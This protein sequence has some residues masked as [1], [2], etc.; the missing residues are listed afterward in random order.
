MKGIGFK[1]SNDTAVL[2]L[3]KDLGF[4]SDDGTPT[5]RYHDY[6]DKSRSKAVMAEALREA[7]EGVFHISEKPGA[8]DRSAIIG[9]FKAEHNVSDRVAQQSTTTFY[10]LLKLADLDA[11]RGSPPR[12]KKTVSKGEEAKEDIADHERETPPSQFGSVGLRY[13][14]EIHLP[15]SKDIEVYNAI[16]KSLK[17]HLIDD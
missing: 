12:K 3:L 17:E 11:Q 16:F 5:R 9:K 15:A 7:Y 10:A 2:P 1:S 8:S 14:V 4:L 6:R 13:N